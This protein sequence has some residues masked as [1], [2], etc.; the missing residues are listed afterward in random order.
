MALQVYEIKFKLYAE[1]QAEVDALQTELT[2]F[3]RSKR[4]Q[5]VAVKASRLIKAIQQFRNNIFVH[6]YLNQ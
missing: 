5:G 6:N 3:V 2:E 1:N 4:E